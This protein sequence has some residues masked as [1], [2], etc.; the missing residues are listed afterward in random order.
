MTHLN[1]KPNLTSF[2]IHVFTEINGQIANL[3]LKLTE[4]KSLVLF[5]IET[6]SSTFKYK[7]VDETLT[8]KI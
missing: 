1:C 7:F 8:L 4:F 5:E 3:F 2:F 6:K